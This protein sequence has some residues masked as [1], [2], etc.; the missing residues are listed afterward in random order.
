[1]VETPDAYTAIWRALRLILERGPLVFRGA[2][3]FRLVIDFQQ[4]A[5]GI[6]ELIGFAVAS[7]ALDPAPA[8]AIAS[9]DCTSRSSARGL[10]ARKAVWP[11]PGC[12]DSVSLSE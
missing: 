3:L 12:A 11:M 1:M 7:I 5:I 6:G 8:M 2:V 9:R 10:S 4:V